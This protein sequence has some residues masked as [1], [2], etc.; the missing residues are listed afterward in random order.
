MSVTST[1]AETTS[2][3]AT[4]TALIGHLVIYRV[5]GPGT[6]DF[7]QGQ[8]SQEL[9]EVTATFAPRASASTPK[10]RAYL[11]TRLVRDG[12][13][14][15]L[16]IPEAIAE[17]VTTQLKKYLMLFRGT[18]MTRD[19][20]LRIYG[21]LGEEAA[22]A[23][24]GEDRTLPAAPCEVLTLDSGNRLIRTESTAEGLPRFEL[25]GQPEDQPTLPEAAWQASEIA[26]GIASLTP[27]TLETYVP[28][29]LNWQHLR[30]LHFR[31]GCYT[32][33]EVIARMH[34]LGQ[35]KKSL[36]RVGIR[37]VTDPILPGTPILGQGREAGEV[38][39][40][41]PVEAQQWECLAVLRHDAAD[42]GP[43]HLGS[44]QGP[45]VEI[46][47]LPYA[48]PEQAPADT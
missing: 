38:V 3:P 14:V 18:S 5:S 36:F 11:L 21:V 40:A 20:S 7:M 13:D 9:G 44:E 39:N 42:G 41:A 37:D 29:M 34:Y 15:L 46:L 1:H 4:G 47:P 23:L 27:E 12:D 8:L 35:L 6:H 25:W 19:D 31:K 28:Q 32:G 17:A 48:V 16:S 33:Q 30:G 10:G 45:L 26:A 24:A 22:R 43:L 2:L